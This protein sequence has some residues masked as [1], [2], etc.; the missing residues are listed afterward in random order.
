M[1]C[2]LS[3][4]Q[5]GIIHIPCLFNVIWMREL[6]RSKTQQIWLGQAF[7]FLF[8]FLFLWYMYIGAPKIKSKSRP[9]KMLNFNA[10][11]MKASCSAHFSSLSLSSH[12]KAAH[13]TQKTN[14]ILISNACTPALYA[15]YIKEKPSAQCRRFVFVSFF[16]FLNFI[17]FHPLGEPSRSERQERRWA[18][19]WPSFEWWSQTKLN[20]RRFLRS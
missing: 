10:L 8:F 5:A 6:R 1:V 4:H 20:G 14:G 17:L 7:S 15:L 16:I 19:I 12:Y 9:S 3:F 18:N 13:A 11:K 2:C